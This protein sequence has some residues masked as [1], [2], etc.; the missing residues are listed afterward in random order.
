MKTTVGIDTCVVLRLLMGV[1]ADQA[2]RAY[3]FFSDCMRNGVVLLVDDLVVTEVYHALL[4][5]YGVPKGRA[6]DTLR[7]FLATPG[8]RCQGN[9]PDVLAS[10]HGTGA[11]LADR[12]ILADLREQANH[13][14]S[15]D[16]DFC[17]L[18]GVRAL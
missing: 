14:V 2:S 10:Y 12:L 15:F 17:R 8:V 9:A 18:P 4:Y 16:R 7:A 11:G 13:L 5:F 3:R 6:L 1:P